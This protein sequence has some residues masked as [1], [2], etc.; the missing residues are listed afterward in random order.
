MPHPTGRVFGSGEQLY[1]FSAAL[2]LAI[3]LHLHQQTRGSQ[4]TNGHNSAHLYCCVA[5]FPPPKKQGATDRC[6]VLHFGGV[7][8]LLL[9]GGLRFSFLF[10]SYQPHLLLLI[11]DRGASFSIIIHV[12]YV[13]NTTVKG[14]LFREYFFK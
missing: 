11:S 13:M 2:V 7:I 1:S 4:A 8:L 10:T 3:T 9:C 14:K 6:Q 12:G 5:P